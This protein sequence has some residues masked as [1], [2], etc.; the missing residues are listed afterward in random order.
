M[1]QNNG[2]IYWGYD[3]LLERQKARIASWD[4]SER[5]KALV[6]RFLDHLAAT[7]TKQARRAKLAWGLRRLCDWLNNDL[8]KAIKEDIERVA[9]RIHESEYTENTKSDYK[10]CLKMFYRWWEDEDS[11]LWNSHEDG[12]L[13]AQRM[14]KYL[15]DHVKTTAPPKE[16]DPGSILREED[17]RQLIEKGCRLE[18]ERAFIRLLH[19][20]GCR[21]GELLGIR[22]KD[23]RH[24]DPL[25]TIRVTGKTGERTIPIRDSIPYLSVWLDRH[26]D[27]DNP[28]AYLW[29][30]MNNRFYGKPLRYD[31]ARRLLN[32]VF[33]RSGVKKPK[34]PHFFRHSRAT[35]DAPKYSEAIQCKLRGWTIGSQMA[36]RY[37]HMSGKDVEDAV[38]RVK[39][40][41]APETQENPSEPQKCPCGVLNEPT[42]RYCQKCGRPLSVGVMLQDEE[43]KN[44]AIEEAM[45]K[46]AEIMADPQQAARFMAFFKAFEKADYQGGG[47]E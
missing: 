25:W 30:S 1:A 22:L 29:L 35:I 11:R 40:L 10:R 28:D 27:K 18:H 21:V 12:R 41:Q 32:R 34:N 6:L 47:S 9:A 26:P 14:Y 36:R 16:I 2:R 23:L 39:G 24:G 46:Y 19:E 3:E 5:N 4:G 37:T 7:G 13:E 44:S 17:V 43:Q 15:R 42:S 45:N 38:L 8:D 20:T 33:E 31:G